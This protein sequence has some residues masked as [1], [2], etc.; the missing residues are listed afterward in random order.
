MNWKNNKFAFYTC[1]CAIILVMNLFVM[2]T[3]YAQN[4]GLNFQG[5][6][7]NPSGVILASQNISLRFS[8]INTSASGTAEY[9]ETRIVATNGQGVFSLVI[10]DTSASVHQSPVWHVPTAR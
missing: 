10:G 2:Q 4:T 7:R 3:I 9:I 8:I 1:I 5:V 6:A